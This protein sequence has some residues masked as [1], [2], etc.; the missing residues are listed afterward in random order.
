LRIL[1]KQRMPES[2]R[3]VIIKSY[4]GIAQ[5]QFNEVIKMGLNHR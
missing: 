4:K 1:I 3:T 5:K 2:T